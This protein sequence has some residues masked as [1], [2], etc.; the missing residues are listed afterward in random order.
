MSKR[1]VRAIAGLALSAALLAGLSGCWDNVPLESRN[2]VDAMGF[3]PG[4]RPGWMTVYFEFPTPMGM[5]SNT[6]SSSGSSSG[7]DI[8]VLTGQGRTLGQAFASAQAKSSR[9][10]YLGHVEFLVFSTRLAAAQFLTIVQSLARI[11]TLEK[12]PFVAASSVPF[13]EILGSSKPQ[14]RFPSLYYV[15]L[16]SCPQCQ[17]FGLG[18]RFWQL[19]ERLVTPGV[20]PVLPL[21]EPSHQSP[22]VNRVAL[23]RGP[24]FVHA[25]NVYDT[26]AYALIAGHSHKTS[27]Y[28]PGRWQANL[29]FLAGPSHVEVGVRGR[30]VV[31][32]LQVALT[33]TVESLNSTTETPRQLAAIARLGSR[34]LS[35]MMAHFMQD[36]QKLDVDPLGIG[37][38]LSWVAPRQFS[39]LGPWH[40]V[41]PTVQLIV[42]CQLHINKMG[43]LK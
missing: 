38:L 23:Y 17:Q 37:R 31:A 20:D 29:I 28:L 11:G 25:L 42:T 2:L 21:I 10:L 16:F 36:T 9:D 7:P 3:Y 41:Y 33:G 19:E 14:A 32:H 43:D 12:T 15:R 35:A 39:R 6:T 22:I 5:A 30:H 34:Q 24:H 18:V 4:P 13:D 27:L 26:T 40:R 8:S 1:W